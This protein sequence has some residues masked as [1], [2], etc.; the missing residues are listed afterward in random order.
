[1]LDRGRHST[2]CQS[3]FFLLN[4][5]S[6]IIPLFDGLFDLNKIIAFRDLILA[7]HYHLHL[8]LLPITTSSLLLAYGSENFLCHHVKLLILLPEITTVDT[9]GV[10]IWLGVDVI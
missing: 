5:L 6:L 7:L 8:C 2:H 1:M 3:R 10:G 4:Y 9:I